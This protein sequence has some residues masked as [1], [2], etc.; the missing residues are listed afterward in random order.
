M[1]TM[2]GKSEYL[3]DI[4]FKDIKQILSDNN[5]DIKNFPKRI[6]IDFELALQ[7]SVKNNFPQSIINFSAFC[8]K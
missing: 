5:F 3:Y 2:T 8:S 1:I 7:K 6:M 4:I